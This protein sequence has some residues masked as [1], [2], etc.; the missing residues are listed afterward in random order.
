MVIFN[1][2]GKEPDIQAKVVD[3]EGDAT[4]MF[5]EPFCKIFQATYISSCK[6]ETRSKPKRREVPPKTTIPPLPDNISDWF[7]GRNESSI[8]RCFE[9]YSVAPDDPNALVEM[10]KTSVVEDG[11]EYVSFK[12]I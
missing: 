11:I 2:L 4:V 12:K 3:F 5:L 7:L 10:L 8:E 1:L 9:K 6:V